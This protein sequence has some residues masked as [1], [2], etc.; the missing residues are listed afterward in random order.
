MIAGITITCFSASYALALAFELA[1]AMVRSRWLNVAALGML[2]MGLLLHTS[3]LIGL[4]RIEMSGQTQISLFSHWYDWCLLA[5]WVLAAACLGL[6]LRRIPLVGILMLPL[7]L[8]LIGAAQM[9]KSSPPFARDDA[10]RYWGMLHGVSLLVGTVAVTIGFVAGVMYLMQSYRLKHKLPPSSTFK[11]P[12]LEWLLRLNAESLL[13]SDF[14][15]AIGVLT[16]VVMNSIGGKA[17]AWSEPAVWS[18]GV[19]LLWLVGA[20]LLNWLY[21]PA[22]Q[23]RKVAYLTMISFGFLAIVL[24][25]VLYSQH[26]A[27]TSAHTNPKRHTSP[28]RKRG[29]VRRPLDVA[30]GRLYAPS[31]DSV[32][33]ANARGYSMSPLRGYD[34]ASLRAER[35][36]GPASSGRG[37]KPPVVGYDA[38]RKAPQ[39]RHRALIAHI[40]HVGIALHGR[41]LP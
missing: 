35:P 1:R 36:G 34:A 14:F 16:G 22:R 7:V 3:Y 4:A 20:L 23:G 19:L 39:G 30:P 13:I 17:I 2:V 24:G 29:F 12:S 40:A 32:P 18:S 5:A 27:G 33:R 8:A 10:L 38:A 11:L 26:A 6:S 9:F 28:T 31:S 15:L 25:L 21:K 41:P 37:R